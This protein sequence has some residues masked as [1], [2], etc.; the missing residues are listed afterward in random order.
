MPKRKPTN[1]D[2][3]SRKRSRRNGTTRCNYCL[4][5]K[6]LL[7]GKSYCATCAIDSTECCCCHR[8]LAHQLLQENGICR[9]C[10][11]KR[12][13]KTS[14]MASATIVNVSPDDIEAINP[15]TY[16]TASRELIFDELQD[17]LSQ[18]KGIKWRLVM[19]VR[20][21]KYN[22][23]QEEVIQE[24]VFYGD[25][26]ILLHEADFNSQLNEQIACI[27]KKIDEFVKLGSGWSV[28][29][30]ISLELHI[31]PYQPVSKASCYVS[32][33][34]YIA[35]KKAVLNIVN[36]DDLCFVWCVLAS[37]HNVGDNAERVSKYIQYFNELN[38]IKFSNACA[39]CEKV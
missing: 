32:T 37:V 38:W 17:R 22:R 23:E 30:I 31:V 19:A 2:A 29:K 15:L 27:T 18:F 28:D 33:P 35:T 7:S 6:D 20:M 25:V 9:S 14:L 8:P 10:N 24:V 34:R 36:D 5:V 13:K 39:R 1:D 26:E 11:N 21:I 3:P 12:D 16:A 4:L